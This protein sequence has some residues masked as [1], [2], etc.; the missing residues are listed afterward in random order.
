MIQFCCYSRPTAL[1][2]F[3]LAL[4]AS[5]AAAQEVQWRPD[6][7]AARR[8]AVEKGRPLVL[9]FDTPHC[10]WCRKLEASTL[11]DAS[12]VRVL[13]EQ[14]IP[15]KLDGKREAY[16]S[17][18]LGIRSYPTLV[19]AAPDGRILAVQEGFV[20]AVRFQQQLQRAL[21][22]TDRA[23]EMNR[24]YQEA[25]GAIA[26]ADYPRA[27]TLLKKVTAGGSRGQAQVKAT[28]LLA[29]LERQAAGRLAR[30]KQL[31]DQGQ[32]AETVAVLRDLLRLYP[33]TE[34]AEQARQ[35]LA[36]LPE[37]AASPTEQRARQAR[38][39][40][41]LA[42][43]SYDRK[44]YLCCL[45]QCEVLTANY[46]DLPEGAQAKALAAAIYNDTAW[47][48]QACEDL[49][50]R[51]GTLYLTLAENLLHRGQLQQAVANLE[52][53]VQITAGTPQAE[54]VRLRLAQLRGQSG[55]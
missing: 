32:F 49:N 36:S 13:N 29:E 10:F 33:G 20:D 40:L 48:A 54:A 8:E 53:A 21:A 51:L 5:P 42:Q 46:I 52:R 55:R 47:V 16:L 9:V 17:Q 25:V 12:V 26:V 7:Q 11:R 3:V 45:D 4:W 19:L 22:S 15:L 31:E 41:E 23:D 35:R 18:V 28:Q 43:E 27:I 34:A 6:Y 37:G 1:G 2:L 44:E 14:T 39:L 30:S 50:R 24:V 38:A